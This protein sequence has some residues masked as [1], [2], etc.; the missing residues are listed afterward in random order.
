MLRDDFIA[1]YIFLRRGSKE[2]GANL[3]SLVSNCRMNG[4]RSKLC[5]GRFRGI[6]GSIPLPEEWSNPETD[7]LE[8]WS[9]FKRDLDNALNDM[10]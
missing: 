9:L 4:S 7:F 3:F 2:G 5:Q 10:L 8:R 6:L 1:L